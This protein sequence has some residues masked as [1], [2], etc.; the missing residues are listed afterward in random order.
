MP[1]IHSQSIEDYLKTIYVL[2]DTYGRATTTQLAE[3]LGVTPASVTGMIQKLAETEPPLLVYQKHHGVILTPEGEKAALRIIRHH[4]L[5]E[6][7]LI[8]TLGYS[9]DEVHEEADRLEHVISEELEDRM[10]QALGEPSQDPHGEP[11]PSRDLQLPPSSDIRLSELR[12][13]QCADI[14]RVDAP[15]AE[16]LRYLSSIG[17]VPNTRFVVTE[18]SPFDGNLVLHLEG[19][20]RTMV[21]GPR[22]TEHIFIKVVPVIAGS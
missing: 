15:D 5:L 18:Y 22:V 16:F 7:F 8:R 20:D 6:L 21:L 17:L 10:A 4:R 1:D 3:R 19:Q 14:E 12:P 2:T 9:W 13:G 11:I